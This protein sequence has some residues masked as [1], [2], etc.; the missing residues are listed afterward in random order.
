MQSQSIHVS[1]SPLWPK[2]WELTEKHV[3]QESEAEI[4]EALHCDN[5]CK[6]QPGIPHICPIKHLVW[7]LCLNFY[8]LLAYALK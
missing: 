1:N 4:E 5:L 2:S 8:V 3:Q 6:D 7:T